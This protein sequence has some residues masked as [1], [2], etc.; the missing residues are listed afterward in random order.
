MHCQ[1]QVAESRW[2]FV[3][4]VDPDEGVRTRQDLLADFG[5]DNTIV[6]GGHFAGHVFGR[7]RNG[8]TVNRQLP[9]WS[10]SAWESLNHTPSSPR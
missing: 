8:Q 3:F 6:A 7:V 9:S 5:D 1:V 4:D 2:S 10:T